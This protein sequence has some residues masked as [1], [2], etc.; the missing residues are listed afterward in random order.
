MGIRGALAIVVIGTALLA[1]SWISMTS[2]IGLILFGVCVL[3]IAG[4]TIT[5]MRRGYD[6]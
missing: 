2:W 3:M 4:L 5:Y 1:L 6:R